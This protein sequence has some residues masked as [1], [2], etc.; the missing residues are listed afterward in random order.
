MLFL[1]VWKKNN[2]PH[3]AIKFITILIFM[4]T[5]YMYITYKHLSCISKGL[6]FLCMFILALYYARK[7]NLTN[8]RFGGNGE[9]RDAKKIEIQT[10]AIQIPNLKFFSWR[11]F[12]LKVHELCKR[13][14]KASPTLS[15]LRTRTFSFLMEIALPFVGQPLTGRDHNFDSYVIILH[16][17]PKKKALTRYLHW[18]RKRG[19]NVDVQNF[20][21][22][23]YYG[24]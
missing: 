3:K 10:R 14:I 8:V 6:R 16:V 4:L 20:L 5:K 2:T 1:R 12:H 19:P 7:N 15:T 9:T 13:W 21:H 23:P 24:G 11:T 18:L 17:S 22:N